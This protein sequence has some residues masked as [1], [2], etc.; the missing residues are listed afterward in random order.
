[1]RTAELLPSLDVSDEHP[2]AYHM[3]E[4]SSLRGQCLPDDLDAAHGLEI[5][6]PHGMHPS[7]RCDRRS[8]GDEH[9][10]SRP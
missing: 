8:A 6:I 3:A 4:S 10:V 1:M 5:A 9:T 7:T 2:C